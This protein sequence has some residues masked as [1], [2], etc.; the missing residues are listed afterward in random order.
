VLLSSVTP[1]AVVTLCIMW[2]SLTL[3]RSKDKTRDDAIAT[4]G[5]KDSDTANNK[6]SRAA[7][8]CYHSNYKELKTK[9]SW[10]RNLPNV[11]NKFASKN[12]REKFDGQEKTFNNFGQERIG[13]VDRVKIKDKER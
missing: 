4:A 10:F 1:V 2:S 8:F 11:I 12:R 6:L 7:T 5:D 13:N 9:K 3:R